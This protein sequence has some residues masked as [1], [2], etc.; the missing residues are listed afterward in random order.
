MLSLNGRGKK[1]KEKP[2]SIRAQGDKT[3]VPL[4]KTE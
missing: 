3:F 4:K 1:P 2:K